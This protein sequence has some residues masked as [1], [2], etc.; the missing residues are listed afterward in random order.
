MQCSGSLHG[1][2]SASSMMDKH[3]NRMMTAMFWKPSCYLERLRHDEKHSN[4]MMIA[5]FRKSSWY[6]ERCNYDGKTK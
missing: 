1:T 2:W 4:I 6:L 5:M 3:S